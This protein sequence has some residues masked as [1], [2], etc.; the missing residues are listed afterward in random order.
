MCIRD[1][2]KRIKRR[3]KE[4]TAS[5]Y[6]NNIILNIVVGVA[7]GFLSKKAITGRSNSKL[8]RF[9]GIVLQF[10]ITSLSLIHI[11]NVILGAQLPFISKNLSVDYTMR[12]TFDYNQL[13][14]IFKLPF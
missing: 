3:L 11:Y 5:P 6:L 12:N 9:L 13:A 7:T 1:R 14:I 2:V 8:R 10:G 4:F